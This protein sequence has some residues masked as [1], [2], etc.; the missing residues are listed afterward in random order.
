MNKLLL[1]I[2]VAAALYYGLD[3]QEKPDPAVTESGAPAPSGY[4]AIRA[5]FDEQLSGVQVSGQGTVVKLLR[6]DNDGS[7]HQRF[8]LELPSGQ[9]LLVAHNIDLAPRIAGLATGDTVAFHGVYEWNAQGGVLHWTH[10]DPRGQHE[11]G[12]LRRAGRTYQ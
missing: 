7:R 6:D 4:D 9:T 12:W 1:A 2:A 5:A 11:A 10:H 3:Q 8:V